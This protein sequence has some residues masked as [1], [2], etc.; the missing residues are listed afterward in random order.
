MP[1]SITYFN[2]LQSLKSFTEQQSKGTLLV[3]YRNLPEYP[4]ITLAIMI[5]FDIPKNKYELDLQWMC[6]GL[7][8][9]GDTLQESY[10]YSFK[11]L[12]TLLSY[13]KEKYDISIS[14]IPLNYSFD[15][16]K[17]PNP[18]KDADKKAEYEAAW[19]KFH[20]AFQ[21]GDFLDASLN[22]TYSTI[23]L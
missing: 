20:K 13:L 1:E 12:E 18:I 7:D 21:N 19:Q 17:H 16:E 6:L 9:Y 11:N 5:V 15:Q 2:D 4:G 8:L 10:V 14:D 3:T 23:G 22:L